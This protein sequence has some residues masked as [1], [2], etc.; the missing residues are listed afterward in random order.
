MTG[1]G[2]QDGRHGLGV[3]GVVVVR[4]RKKKNEGDAQIG[5]GGR[6]ERERVGL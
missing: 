6:N 3:E 4:R 5:T 2:A 1:D